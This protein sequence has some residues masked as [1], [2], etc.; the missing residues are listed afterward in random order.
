MLISYASQNTEKKIMSKI[1]HED[2][3]S[4]ATANNKY[5]KGTKIYLQKCRKCKKLTEN[6]HL[7]VW[8]TQKDCSGTM[9]GELD[10]D[11]ILI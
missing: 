9:S 11:Q 7:R 4:T 8:C 6:D 2:Q 3:E 1:S 10:K 5:P